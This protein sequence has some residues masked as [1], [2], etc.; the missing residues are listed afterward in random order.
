[1]NLHL[2]SSDDGRE[3][4]EEFCEMAQRLYGVE[5]SIGWVTGWF[6]NAIETA[7]ALQNERPWRH[8]DD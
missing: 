3:W 5:L 1:M 2:H 8:L 4:A 6:A 7:K